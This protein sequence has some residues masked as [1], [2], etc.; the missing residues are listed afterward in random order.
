MTMV[1]SIHDSGVPW[2]QPQ[3]APPTIAGTAEVLE[4]LKFSHPQSILQF[5]PGPF[6]LWRPSEKCKIQEK[7]MFL[8]RASVP[9]ETHVF[10][11]LWAASQICLISGKCGLRKWHKHLPLSL[12]L[13]AAYR[14]NTVNTT[15]RLIALLS[16]HR[17][18]NWLVSVLPVPRGSHSVTR[19]W[20]LKS[21]FLVPRDQMGCVG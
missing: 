2:A 8:L 10:P 19:C 15:E 14:Q 13:S 21:G 1:C 4:P 18:S 6:F 17:W 7:V 9:W 20:S 3:T 11:S 16:K 5:L 12:W